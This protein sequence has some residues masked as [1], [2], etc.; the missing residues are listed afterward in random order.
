MKR[1]MNYGAVFAAVVFGL[2]ILAC[3]G[4][5]SGDGSGDGE[6]LGWGLTTPASE[7]GPPGGV[8]VIIIQSNHVALGP[9]N[10]SLTFADLPP[11]W[12]GSFGNSSL[13][14]GEGIQPTTTATITIPATATEGTVFP[15]TIVG[16]ESSTRFVNKVV[17]VT[18]GA[19]LTTMLET[20]S[21]FAS[22]PGG[23]YVGEVKVTNGPPGGVIGSMNTQF[24]PNVV[25]WY[26]PDNVLL[27][28]ENRTKTYGVAAIVTDSVAGVGAHTI[29]PQFGKN[30]QPYETSLTFTV[31]PNPDRAFKLATHGGTVDNTVVGSEASFTLTMDLPESKA[32]EYTFTAQELHPTLEATF[33]P[34]TV[35]VDAAGTPFDV[36]VKVRRIAADPTNEYKTYEFVLVGTHDTHPETNLRQ[37]LPIF[38]SPR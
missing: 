37:V 31:P 20:T 28:G 13:N 16:R 19:A 6:G 18:V 34:A 11:G 22:H 24:V 7:T 14:I 26:R 35:T 15:I 2:T 12:T 21:V 29:V 30:G 1:T 33:T 27:L 38:A 23:L 25:W 3:G 17:Q 8:A 10:V 32:G 9:Y 36:E 4:L 5:G